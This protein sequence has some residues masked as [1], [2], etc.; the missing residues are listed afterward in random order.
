MTTASGGRIGH[1]YACYFGW[2]HRIAVFHLR[3][4]PFC[5]GW[6]TAACLLISHAIALMQVVA[7][8][9]R[10]P[11]LPQQADGR[12]LPAAE[13]AQ[14]ALQLLERSRSLDGRI[15]PWAPGLSMGELKAE[16]K[17]VEAFL[18]HILASNLTSL[19]AGARL[20]ERKL[21]GAWRSHNGWLRRAVHDCCLQSV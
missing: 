7:V 17:F 1:R 5:A 19:P 2:W 13:V 3:P 18:R 8:Y 15:Q 16:R 10:N 11:Q 21:P 14:R 6:Y 4:T 12:D 20:A 9:I